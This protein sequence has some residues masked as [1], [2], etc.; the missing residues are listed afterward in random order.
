MTNNKG[1]TLMELMAVVAIVAILVGISIGSFSRSAE[2]TILTDGLVGAS[3]I[4]SAYDSYYYEHNSYPNSLKSLPISLTGGTMA[5]TSI[6]TRNFTYTVVNNG[7]GKPWYIKGQKNNGN[8][9]V[10]T[11]LETNKPQYPDRCVGSNTD[12]QEFCASMGYSCT[13]DDLTGLKCYSN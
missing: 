2:K 8:Y 9:Y 1:F 7:S 4:A 11:Y 10:A 5:T 3:T 6:T 13:K 12:G